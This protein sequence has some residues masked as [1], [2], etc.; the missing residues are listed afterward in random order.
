MSALNN[1]VPMRGDDTALCIQ[2]MKD[3]NTPVASRAAS[4]TA[5]FECNSVEGC[6]GNKNAGLHEWNLD[7]DL[8]NEDMSPDISL[9]SQK[10]LRYSDVESEGSE[11]GISHENSTDSFPASREKLREDSNSEAS[12]F[13]PSKT[14]LTQHKTGKDSTGSLE[15][16]ISS[17]SSGDDHEVIPE[18]SSASRP[19]SLSLSQP[20]LGAEKQL[21]RPEPS[22]KM[23]TNVKD[24]CESD[25]GTKGSPDVGRPEVIQP[26][27]IAKICLSQNLPQGTIT[28]KGDMIQF[29]ADDFMQKIKQSSPLSHAGK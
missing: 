10:T 24:K 9:S 2:K 16:P 5:S 7:G 22:S 20:L 29:V 17:V 26:Q 3:K 13:C 21:N 18:S 12:H 6:N 4:D 25:T 23:C 15:I 19:G 8:E 27:D 28:R 11:R 14:S 1:G